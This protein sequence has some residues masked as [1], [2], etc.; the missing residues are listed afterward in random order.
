MIASRIF[1]NLIRIIYLGLQTVNGQAKKQAAGKKQNP[2]HVFTTKK[3]I[4]AAQ[5]NQMKI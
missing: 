1:G 4:K 5:D 2:F 3:G